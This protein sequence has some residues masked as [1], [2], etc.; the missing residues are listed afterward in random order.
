[1]IVKNTERAKKSHVNCFVAKSEKELLKI[2]FPEVELRTIN[3][4]KV[5]KVMMQKTMFSLK[6]L[7]ILL[8]LFR[9]CIY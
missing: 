8:L 5:N 9:Y 3:S 7:P 1:M 4:P 6:T 2:P